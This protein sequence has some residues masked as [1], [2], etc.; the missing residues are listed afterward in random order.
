[1]L[2]QLCSEKGKEILFCS[3]ILFLTIMIGMIPFTKYS[4]H[5]A[6]EHEERCQVLRTDNS[7]VFQRGI[8]KQGEQSVTVKLLTGPDRGREM[9]AMNL[10][11]G[12]VELEWFYQPGEKAIIGYSEKDHT[13]VAARMLEP[14][15]EGPLLGIFLLFFILILALAG[16]TGFKAM[17]S[18]AFSMVVIWKV[19]LPLNLEGRYDPVI[20][21]MLI[22]AI[23]C[24]V[25]I[26]LV[27]G[28][29]KKG[30][31]AFLGA[32]GGCIFTWIILFLF[33]GMMKV[34]G[35][36]AGFS[37]AL[38]FSG[39]EHLDLLK[40]YYAAVVLSAS[41]AIMDIAMDISAS[42]TE[43]HEKRPDISRLELIGSGFNIGRAVIGTM[44]TTL[45][46]AYSGGF[47]TMLMYLMSKGISLTRILNMN[48][49]VAEM[50]K[51]VSGTIGLTLVVPLTAIICGFILV[52]FVEKERIQATGAK[53]MKRTE[54]I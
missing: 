49:V 12:S 30:W 38:R 26:F 29:S 47:M 46:L 9:T 45:L 43:I 1:M 3:V 42:M 53:R 6:S 41:G 14:V 4:N 20:L 5:P 15:R 27:A 50:L 54:V 28:F 13:I 11:Q 52:P 25:I 31:G 22:V 33:G 19:L 23:L 35:A 40:L 32:F 2:K 17:L 44:T 39:F 10:L 36:T 21:A 48:Y 34:N 51:T 24:F 8:F 7:M 16:W 18:F 37:T